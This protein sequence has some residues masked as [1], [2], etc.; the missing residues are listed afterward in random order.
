MC[1]HR[2]GR[3]GQVSERGAELA[4]YRPDGGLHDDRLK[5]AVR[6]DR[7]DQGIAK[8]MLSVRLPGAR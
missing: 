7:A 5:L 1:A 3:I 8:S 4:A 6:T 2:S